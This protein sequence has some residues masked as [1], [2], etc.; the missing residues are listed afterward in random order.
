MKKLQYAALCDHQVPETNFNAK[1]IL[2][3]INAHKVKYTFAAD[4]K[5]MNKYHGKQQHSCDYPCYIC[6]APNWDFLNGDYDLYTY[7]M[8]VTFFE[9]WRI[10]SGKRKDLKDYFNQEFTP[11]GVEHMS[12]DELNEL[13]L[14]KCPPPSL[15]LLLCVNTIVEKLMEVWEWGLKTWLEQVNFK[16]YFGKTLE[17]NQCSE[18]LKM[19]DALDNLAQEHSRFDIAPFVRVFKAME[20]IKKA[21]FCDDLD[22]EFESI[23]DEFKASLIALDEMHSTSITTKYHVL[24]IHVKQY[25]QMT[26]KTLKLTSEQ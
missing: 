4:L 10:E 19:Y 2:N 16:N 20:G 11:V 17:G 24:S 25:C 9:K 21:C 22:P 7:K 8:M 5:M 12:A 18:V 15:H 13:T 14:L 3:H 1:A 6:T 26:N 23:C